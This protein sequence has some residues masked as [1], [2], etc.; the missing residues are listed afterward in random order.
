MQR[1]ACDRVATITAALGH[2]LHQKSSMEQENNTSTRDLDAERE[3]LLRFVRAHVPTE[4]DHALQLVAESARAD[5]PAMQVV[6]V[7]ST[8]GS[9]ADP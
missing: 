1:H 4:V 9:H 7:M 8:D 3:E 5:W 2:R 6:A